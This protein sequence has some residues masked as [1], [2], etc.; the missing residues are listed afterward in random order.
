MDLAFNEIT[1]EGYNDEDSLEF[2]EKLALVPDWKHK[3]SFHGTIAMWKKEQALLG[4]RKWG[5]RKVLLD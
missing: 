4:N 2:L 5:S 1:T 3:S